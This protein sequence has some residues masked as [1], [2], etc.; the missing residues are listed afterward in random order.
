MRSDYL[1][2]IRAFLASVVSWF[3]KRRYSLCRFPRCSPV[4]LVTG[5][6]DSRAKRRG[7]SAR[8]IGRG[9]SF[10][11]FW[12]FS[13]F[14]AFLC[15]EVVFFGG[16]GFLSPSQAKS[17]GGMGG[18]GG[19]PVFLLG[20]VW[21]Y[22]NCFDDASRIQELNWCK[23]FVDV[24][25]ETLDAWISGRHKCFVEPTEFVVLFYVDRVLHFGRLIPRMV[26]SFRDWT[27][28]S[29]RAREFFKICG[30]G[31]GLGV[32]EPPISNS[33][34]RDGVV[35]Q[36]QLS[37]ENEDNHLPPCEYGLKDGTRSICGRGGLTQ[38]FMDVGIRDV[39]SNI[40]SK[41]R[42]VDPHRVDHMDVEVDNETIE[43]SVA[44]VGGP[45]NVSGSCND[46]D[47]GAGSASGF[48]VLEGVVC[49]PSD[50]PE[51]ATPVK[52]V[53]V[54][55]LATDFVLPDVVVNPTSPKVGAAVQ[56]G[57]QRFS[58]FELTTIFVHP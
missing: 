26:P 2:F 42:Y 7:L 53:E 1:V 8:G 49:S 9:M 25:V 37:T 57:F 50:Y 20:F 43:D 6:V 39:V 11:N 14:L 31:F 52:E 47:K 40:A 44:G 55:G 45:S 58:Y 32:I 27:L 46:G 21:M 34:G 4:A 38:D 19:L 24:L 41:C 23:L 30:G 33:V 35:A 5:G 10:L 54:T 51:F 17:I 13:L 16:Y 56:V 36:P 12:R 22:F 3:A 29:L 15:G 48:V 28:D 18:E